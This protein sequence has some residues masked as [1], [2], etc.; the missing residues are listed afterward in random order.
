MQE[1]G[2]FDQFMEMLPFLIPV[3]LLELGL[4]VWALIDVA[5]RERVKGSKVVWILVIALVGIIGPIIYFI[6]GRDE[7]PAEENEENPKS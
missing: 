4:L 1:V 7:A 3:F 6:F 2:E 5:R